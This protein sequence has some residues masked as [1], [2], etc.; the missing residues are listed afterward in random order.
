[1]RLRI[2]NLT[3]WGNDPEAEEHQFTTSSENQYQKSANP[4]DTAQRS[5]KRW[6]EKGREAGKKIVE[7]DK[8]NPTPTFAAGSGGQEIH[9]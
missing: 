6:A 1:M 7:V 4:G 9:K 5:K 8:D 3:G 2:L